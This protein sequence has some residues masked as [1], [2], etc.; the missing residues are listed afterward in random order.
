M[1][2]AHELDPLL[3]LGMYSIPRAAA[4]IG[5]RPAAVRRWASGYSRRRQGV[6]VSYA[7]VIEREVPG[8]ED[9]GSVTFRDLMEL[10]FVHHFVSRGVNPKVV[11]EAARIARHTTGL[12]HPLASI[13]FST[14]GRRI[15]EEIR[16]AGPAAL[17]TTRER[18]L[19]DVARGQQVIAEVIT[20]YL[21]DHVALIDGTAAAYH[22]PEGH[23]KVVIDPQRR[24][25]R[26]FVEE[27]GIETAVLAD[28]LRAYGS[29]EAVASWFAIPEA[30]VVAGAEF[31]R[32]LAERSAALSHAA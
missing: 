21:R 28:C 15:F 25:G 11:K 20:P 24:F 17:G 26:P 31:E 2:T 27:V 32:L 8:L 13:S 19:L 9:D 14:D 22:P 30:A 5:A 4:L 6:E 7:P 16:L 12:S 1:M 10:L 18:L 23:G 3:G 29:A